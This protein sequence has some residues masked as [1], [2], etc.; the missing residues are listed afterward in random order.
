MLPTAKNYPASS[1]NSARPC[2]GY[3]QTG[4]AHTYTQIFTRALIF[5]LFFL[6]LFLFLGLLF[7]PQ[8]VP[9]LPGNLNILK[10]QNYFYKTQLSIVVVPLSVLVLT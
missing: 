1:E 3:E 7:R 9:R 4:S 2:P 6:F 10:I 8:P 5:I